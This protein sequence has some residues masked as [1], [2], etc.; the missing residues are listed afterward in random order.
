MPGLNSVVTG[1][2]VVI[3]HN[4]LHEDEGFQSLPTFNTIVGGRLKRPKIQCRYF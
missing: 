1:A 4:S 2:V 3:L